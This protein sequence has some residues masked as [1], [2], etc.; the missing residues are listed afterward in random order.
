MEY[1]VGGPWTDREAWEPACNRGYLVRGL[2]R[3]FKRIRCTDIKNYGWSGQD[4]V[5]DFLWPAPVEESI[6]WIITNP[7]SSLAEKF[8]LCARD[9]ATIGT[10]LL[11]RTTFLKGVGRYNR[12]F[13]NYPP[14][15]VAPFVERVPMVNGRCDPNASTATPYCWLVWWQSPWTGSTKV[16]WIPPCRRELEW[17]GDYD[18]PEK[19]AQ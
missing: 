11:V 17:P 8:A 9:I 19:A 13:K 4:E 18:P 14:S 3:Y 6:A 1:V 15:I 5:L 16:I 12:L 10:A 2:E 7:P